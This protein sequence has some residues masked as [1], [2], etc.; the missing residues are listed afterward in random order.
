MSSGM[1]FFI[2]YEYKIYAL[3]HRNFKFYKFKNCENVDEN[4]GKEEERRNSEA[5]RNL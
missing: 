5:I 1:K 3:T 2:F 4:K